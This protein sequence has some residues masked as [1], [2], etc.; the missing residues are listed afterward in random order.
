MGGDLFD[1]TQVFFSIVYHL[2]ADQSAYPFPN[3]GEYLT[4][5]PNCRSTFG[6]DSMRQLLVLQKWQTFIRCRRD[7]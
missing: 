7:G 4:Q 1:A 3:L 6:N 5:G 2:Y